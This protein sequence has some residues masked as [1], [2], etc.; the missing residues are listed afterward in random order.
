MSPAVIYNLKLE[1][2]YIGFSMK[3][4]NVTRKSVFGVW[5]QVK[6][7]L[8]YSATYTSKVSNGAKIRNQV[9]HPFYIDE[10]INCALLQ[11]L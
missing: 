3:L 8:V 1:I 4:N 11:L 10:D 9:P 2:K 5:C 6:L 7:E